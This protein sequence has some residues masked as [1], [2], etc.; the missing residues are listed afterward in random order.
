MDGRRTLAGYL[1]VI[2]IAVCRFLGHV[3]VITNHDQD[4]LDDNLS[5]CEKILGV[6]NRGEPLASDISWREMMARR[7]IKEIQAVVASYVLGSRY[8]WALSEHQIKE[9]TSINQKMVKYGDMMERYYVTKRARE[10]ESRIQGRSQ[11]RA[12]KKK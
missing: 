9:L 10:F 2:D 4:F 3:E 12:R 1:H 8:A 11:S 5:A 7:A 6:R